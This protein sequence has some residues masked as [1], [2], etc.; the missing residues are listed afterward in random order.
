MA[1][2]AVLQRE[3]LAA[4]LLVRLLAR[5]RDHV[6]REAVL[7]RECLAAHGAREVLHALTTH[8]ERGV[9]RLQGERRGDEIVLKYNK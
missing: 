3:C 5:V 4:H 6:A 2:E 8:G 1:R 9:D 7:Q